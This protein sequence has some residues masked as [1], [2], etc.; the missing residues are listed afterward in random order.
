MESTVVKII[1]KY[2]EFQKKKE[3]KGYSDELRLLYDDDA[4]FYLKKGI[5]KKLHYM[6]IQ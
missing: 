3:Q 5:R 2:L 4:K 6:R 1:E